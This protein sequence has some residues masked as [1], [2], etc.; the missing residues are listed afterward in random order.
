[1][2]LTV[3]VPFDRLY[4]LQLIDCFGFGKRYIL[5]SSDFLK[6]KHDIYIQYNSDI[7]NPFN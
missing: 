7:F 3:F 2:T 5:L 1:M 6:S 4:A